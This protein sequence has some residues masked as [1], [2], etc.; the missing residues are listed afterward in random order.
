MKQNPPVSPGSHPDLLRIDA[1][2]A[3][4]GASE[5]RSHVEVCVACRETLEQMRRTEE[6]LKELQS[7]PPEIPV[8]VNRALLDAFRRHQQ[9]SAQVIPFPAWRRWTVPAATAA[10]AVL[11]VAMLL[12]STK[13]SEQVAQRKVE[14]E[15]PTT[16]AA[17]PAA[18]SWDVNGDGRLDILDAYRLALDLEQGQSVARWDADG[19]GEVG[20]PDVDTLA[21]RAVSLM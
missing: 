10:A 20:R 9:P 1:V 5:D 15:A 11:V 2:R 17:E 18:P 7:T 3:G 21:R 14:T 4:E 6:T 19:D 12:P 13:F 8:A 16:I